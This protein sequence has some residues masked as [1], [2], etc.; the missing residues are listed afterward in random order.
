[1]SLLFNVQC[2]M[3]INNIIKLRAKSLE[4]IESKPIS[5][6]IN[7]PINLPIINQC[8]TLNWNIR[9]GTKNL[10]RKNRSPEQTIV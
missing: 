4:F 6:P 1:L 3:Y 10:D 7:M 5:L 2:T 8:L 9:Q